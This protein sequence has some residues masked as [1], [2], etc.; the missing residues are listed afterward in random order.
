MLGLRG[1][2]NSP[3][4]SRKG[5]LAKVYAEILSWPI[6]SQDN[7]EH[8]NF[9]LAGRIILPSENPHFDPDNGQD[10]EDKSE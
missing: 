1:N 3:L 10:K 4:N 8:G 2:P 6:S 5:T 7:T 9:E